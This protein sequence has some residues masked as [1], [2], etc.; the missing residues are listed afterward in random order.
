MANQSQITCGEQRNLVGKFVQ[1]EMGEP[2]GAEG[3]LMQGLC[4]LASASQK[5]E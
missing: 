1:L 5:G 4:V 3:A 2:E